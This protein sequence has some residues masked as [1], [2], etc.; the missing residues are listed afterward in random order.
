MRSSR[1][2]ERNGGAG[3]GARVPRWPAVLAW[4][5][6]GVA[7]LLSGPS[8]AAAQ[9]PAD[10]LIFGPT[11]YLRT[12]GPPNQYT[13]T[14]TVPTSVG[15]PFVL[16][17]VNGHSNGQNRISSAW[18][19]VNN[20]Q[21][22]GPSD[23][24]QT[25]A[26]VDRT[27]T[28]NPG[29]NTL[30]VKVASS[31]GAYLTISVYGTKILPTP[32]QLTPNP[33]NLTAGSSGTLTASIAPAPTT[34]GSLS[35]ANSQSAIATVPSSVA[36]AVNQTSIPIPVTAVAVGNAQ[37]TVTLNG[38]SVSTTVAVSAAPP[39][40]TSLQPASATITQGG[41]G[42]LTVTISAVQS[43]PTTVTLTSSVAGIASVPATV[44]VPTGQTTA[45]IAVSANTPGTAVITASLNGT[46]AGST[47]TV[48]PNLP[49]IVSLLPPTT[50]INLGATGGLTV[51][52]SAVQSS[53]TTIQVTAAPGGIVTVPATV[54][55]LAGE[56]TA[57]VPVTATALG[58]AMVHV[59]LNSSMAESAVQVTPPPPAVRSLL[60]SPLP[61]VIDASGTLTV[62]LNAGQL[63]NT[64]VAL[65][66][67]SP[68]LVQVPAIVT[69]PAGQTQATFT[70]TGLAVGSATVTASLNGTTRSAIVQVQLPPP[71]VLSLLPNP[72]PL[73]QGATGSLLLTINAA[74]VADTVIPLTNT[75]P[76]IVQ[77]PA[78][79]TVPANQLSATMSVTALLAGSATI[80]A[81]INSSTVSTLVQVTPPP[82][83][84]ASLTTVPP[85]PA[86]T[87]LTKPKGSPGILRVTLDRAPTNVT[88][89]TLTSSAPTVAQVPASV[90]VAAGA[91]TAD[92]PVNTVGE[93]TTTI[94]ASLNGGSATATVTVTP[95]ELVLLT[96]SPQNLTLFVGEPQS[97]TATATLTDGTTQEL[98]TDSRLAWTSTNETVATIT[99]S[100]L[101][102]ALAIGTS[103]I[104]ATFTPTT[105]T[106]TSTEITLTVL[107]PPALTLTATPATV[108]VGQALSVTVTSARV[109]SVGGLPVTITS[110]GTG[111]VS[112]ATSITILEN[113]TA[114]QFV[115][116]GVTA[117]SVTLTATAP[118]SIPGTLA[119]TVPLPPPT[120]TGFSPTTG[121]VGTPVTVTGTNLNGSGP[122]STTVQFN[123]TNAI[124]TSVSATS[125]T[126]TVPQGATSGVISVTTPINTATSGGQFLVQATQDF[127][128][129]AA[130]AL[131]VVGTVIQGG[132]VTFA[133]TVS[134]PPGRSFTGLVGLGAVGLPSG[135]TAQFSGPTLTS[136]QTGFVTL[137]VGGSVSPGTVSFNITGS[138]QLEAGPVTQMVPA[139]I[140]VLASGGQTALSGQV[141]RTDG[142]P[143]S[144][145]LMKIIGT[146]LEARTNAAGEFLFQN[147][148]AGLQQL[149]VNANEAVAGY[150]IYHTDLVLT[151]GQVSTFPTI[152]IT[153][154]PPAERFTPLNNATTAQVIT[155]PRF[156]GAEFTI[157][158][159]VTI[160][161][162]DGALKTKI[163]MERLSPEQLPVPPP[164]GPTK[165]VFQ[166]FFGTPMGGQ[167]SAPIPVTLPNDL[168][169]DP[170]EQ[171]ELWYYDA[172]PLGGP[173][174]WKLA[175]M[176]T[177]SSD[178]MKIVSDPGVGIQRFC[179]VCGLPCFINRQAPQP[180]TN[181]NGTKGGDPVDLATGVFTMEKTDLILPGRFPVVLSRTYNPFDPFGTIA[182]FQP[183]LG[184][185]WYLSTDVMLLPGISF[186]RQT[187]DM[188]RLILPGNTRLDMQRQANG[189]FSNNSHPLLKGTVLT[190]FTTATPLISE[191]RF[192][193]GAV[194]RFQR[195]VFGA[196]GAALDFL[197]EMKDRNGNRITIE[198]NAFGPSRIIDSA[199]RE[200][201]FTY[202]GSQITEVHDPIGRTIRYGYTNGR[203]TSV[204]D[205]NGGVTQYNY[206]TVGRILSVT[207]A[208][209]IT[210][211][212][213]EYSPGSGRILR[214]TQADGG[215]WSFRY[216]VTGA[217][218]SGPDCP[219]PPPPGVVIAITLPLRC[220]AEESTEAVQAGYS[221]V[222]G[223]VTST[224]LIDPRGNGT[225]HQ[226]NATGFA[227]E[228]VNPLGQSTK[229]SYDGGN[230]LTASTDALGRTT[231]FTYD[232]AG[233]ITTI[234]DPNNQA[235]RFEYEPT[236]NRV[237]K[238]TNALNQDTLFTYDP[239]GNLLTSTDPLNHTTTL[240]YNTTGQPISVSDPLGNTTAFEYDTVGNLISTTDPVGNRT[241]RLFDAVSRLIQL[242]DARRFATQFGYDPLNR[243]TQITDAMTGLTAFTYDPNGNLLTVTDAEN[244]RTSYTYESMD[245]LK[246]RK[247]PLPTHPAETYDY[248]LAGNLTHFVD[249][250]AQQT[251]FQY[252]AL[253]RRAQATYPD[254]TATFT[255]D[256][257]GRLIKA[258]DT[259]PGAGTIDFAHDN[260]N[261]V[262]QEVTSLGIVSYQYDVLDRRTQM[263]ANGQQPVSYQYDP[264]S[265]LARVEQGAVFAVLGYD[266]A[267]RQTALSYSNGASTSY[268]YDLASRLLSITHN[269]PSGIIEELTSTYDAAGN[270][271]SATRTNGTA[272]LLPSAVASASYDPANQQT[273]FAGAALTYD[274]NG[275]LTSDGTITYVWD[276]RNRLI[277]ISGGATAN[278]NYDALGR[279]T[280][281]T[282]NGVN[283]QF[284]YDGND[285][286]VEIN[287]GTV[288]A[289]Y[290]RSLKIDEPFIRQASPG[291]EY[292]HT[293]ALGSI[294]AL[295]NM[296][297]G[298]ATTHSY[299]PFG[300]TTITGLSPNSF[301]YTGRENDGTGLYY[302]RARYYSV[303][304]QRFI[305]EDPIGFLGKDV[306]FYRY[307]FSN[308]LRF[309]D[310]LGLAVGDWWDLPS[311]L[312][313]S[314][315]IGIE[316]R[317]KRPTAH[318][319]LEDAK[320]H[321]E[322]M[323]RTTQE[324]NDPTAWI[325]GTG[326]E[327]DGILKGQPWSETIMDL[328]NNSVGR[329]AGRNK[330][331]VDPNQ[332]WRLPLNSSQYNPYSKGRGK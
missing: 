242:T 291:N 43:S 233:N 65:M 332:L 324:T 286:V 213:N 271:L 166:I 26:I 327:I 159:G 322:W 27:I 146:S 296:Q 210:Y 179:G 165:S 212:T 277:A 1:Q 278:F 329:K 181:P 30:T 305:Q 222:G 102:N 232:V 214:Q 245:R 130:P 321:A 167:P 260:L 154:P 118:I 41:T 172:S 196:F 276:A 205:A 292:Y 40:L 58:T 318:N 211:L 148:P 266:N 48:T 326:H 115:V 243:V 323:R 119:L 186:F 156:P 320:R 269:G 125:L 93:G 33:L 21:V 36:F 217:T 290:L 147:T 2:H 246:T 28:L 208:R 275:N 282:I 247:D 255:Y 215:V 304:L 53:A 207:D 13:N 228:M 330:S 122:G 112:H 137:T 108:A 262:V 272:S 98:T 316:E 177:V 3:T 319:D 230:Q 297:G 77:I 168:D 66:V 263:V 57:L 42:T 92:F 198:R 182:G 284:A 240:V 7:L 86:G 231:R 206:D 6:L 163:A 15:A 234:T 153:P 171:A 81:A 191:L 227:T 143:I 309:G 162:W 265:R 173:G 241:E 37:I 116:T 11:Q 308:P 54:T 300:K 97:M 113:Q 25:V 135:V 223:T 67:D 225:V 283:T 219:A 201:S 91:L 273:Q 45:P 301:Q 16:H 317:G 73:Q 61:I 195:A 96:V 83:V 51:T 99:S 49:T 174:I 59:S 175:G 72:L 268:A 274:N 80:T 82:P 199:G 5:A 107:T 328:H 185:G 226:F 202:S 235:T 85:D 145:V 204:T 295:S 189:T 8:L 109:A 287:S 136:G 20:V 105:G 94:T 152:W 216:K 249:R 44:T 312:E 75:A 140:Q 183:A 144:N 89:I 104:R 244:H 264:A 9:A 121:T 299:E 60:P 190:V 88:V 193:D 129:S 311:N 298:S 221:F 39:T 218:I 310:P 289:N 32:T 95:A 14:I 52:I 63:T 151:A 23:F 126:T 248:D 111:A 46:S 285:I 250:K 331:S 55:V 197:V 307:A 238:I 302:Y 101:V 106:P 4:V 313:R 133:L 24:G 164:P 79:I 158:A 50:S 128:L 117:G 188:V 303:N 184:P 239:T 258:A 267:G 325:A 47:I 270:R 124:I 220:P 288:G 29:T 19:T 123:T 110:S 251:T 229:S 35:I 194:W 84:V 71:Q 18:V 306:N 315:D 169:L 281:K 256:A 64:E 131:P 294:L 100:G 69:V 141:L 74:Q 114:A 10:Q 78:A 17:I 257:V 293:D 127:I 139:S 38:G 187:P 34:V 132:Q 142:M 252:D 209:G 180:N 31:P 237:T 68:S 12:T 62:T 280:S 203:L 134:P 176:G 149:M 170:G 160:V 56:L 314:Y 253:N 22:A 90:T 87:T 70:V 155:D 224:T 150:P 103:T 192:K 279:R 161:G 261:R 120:I 157:P 178:G 236:F 138:A 76:T 200:I 254:A 259:A